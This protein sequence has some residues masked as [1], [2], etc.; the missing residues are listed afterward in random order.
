M[1]GAKP[2]T[3]I[4]LFGPKKGDV[5]AISSFPNSFAIRNPT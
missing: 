4:E 3:V 2:A 5:N 1:T